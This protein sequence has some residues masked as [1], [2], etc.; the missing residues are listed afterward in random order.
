MRKIG[1]VPIFILALLAPGLCAA[2]TASQRLERLA[3]EAS[4]R[5]LD[6]F[7]VAEIFG[8]GPG[9]RQDRLELTLTDEHRERQRA[10]HRW[11]LRELEGIPAGELDPTEK[12]THELLGWRARDSLEWLAHPF[13]QHSAFT[14]LGGGIAFGLVRV[15][16]TQPFRNE[17]DYGAWHRRLQRYPAFLES[18]ERV[19]RAGAA[20]GVT[21]PRVLVERALAQLEALAPEDMAKSALWKPMTQFPASMDAPARSRVEADYRTLLAGEM[22]PAIRRLASFV[23]DEYLA[24]ART[25]DGFGALPG[26]DTMYRFAV[27]NET[28]T[29]LTPGE[30]HELGLKEVK[31]VQASYLAA[32]EKAGYSGK[33]SGARAWL[34]SRPENYPFTSGEQVIEHL[35]RIHARIVPQLPRLFGRLPKARFE[36]RLTDPAIAA[37]APAQY[38]GPTDDGRPG[39]FAMPVTDPR[40]VSTFGLAALLAHEGM[41]GHHLDTGIKL[42]NKVPEFRRRMWFTAFGEGWALYAES[43]GHQLG[44]YDEPLELLGRYSFELFRAGRLVVDTGL[45][46]RGWTRQQAIRYLVEEC[47]MTEGG[48]TGEVLRY[49]TWPGQAL[50][51]K[52]GELTILELRA[53]AQKR[54]G[55]RFDLRAFHDALLEEG[56]LPLGMLRQRIDAWIDE[57]DKK[58]SL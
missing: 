54:L 52:I 51:Y 40:R 41:P 19:M 36:I 11:I 7:P 20:T 6:L 17:A 26:G 21:T 39:I 16:G 49:M 55:Q 14:P 42:E 37:S 50:G 23:R 56:H 46:A 8:R 35:N 10:H 12:I 38:Y 34:R 31:R 28:T 32:A 9:P 57:Q 2:Q 58:R 29:D 43:L 45:H 3:A 30:I 25:S 18:V 4:E 24:K 5:G 48:A 22:F 27:R 44:L 53:K 15:V 1:S 13:H 47:G 33:V